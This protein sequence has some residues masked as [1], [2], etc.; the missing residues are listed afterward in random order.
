MP[1]TV[2]E[3]AAIH[4]AWMVEIRRRGEDLAAGREVALLWDEAMNPRILG[5]HRGQ[6]V[7]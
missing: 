2:E 6:D 4:A 7:A 1:L 3:Q 5:K